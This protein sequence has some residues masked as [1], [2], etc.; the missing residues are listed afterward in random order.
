LREYRGL[1]MEEQYFLM[2]WGELPV[3]P[4]TIIACFRNGDSLNSG[5]SQVQKTDVR[6]VAAKCYLL[7]TIEKEETL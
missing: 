1:Q 5:S 2:K 3:W 4:S 6:I 7:S